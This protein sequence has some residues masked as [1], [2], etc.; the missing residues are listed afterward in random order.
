M[1]NMETQTAN[2]WLAEQFEYNYCEECGGDAEHHTPVGVL[3]NW[4][5]FCLYPPSPETNWEFHPVIAAY[6][7]AKE[8]P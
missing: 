2:E 6:R 3:G 1:P 5:A 8:R 4:F 7:A